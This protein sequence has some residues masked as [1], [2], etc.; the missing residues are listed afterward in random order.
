MTAFIRRQRRTDR[1]FMPSEVT[2][3]TNFWLINLA[4]VVV[5]FASLPCH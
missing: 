3:N 1:P 5:Q 2:R 4:A